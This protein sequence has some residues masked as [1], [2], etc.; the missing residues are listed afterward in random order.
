M[1]LSTLSNANVCKALYGGIVLRELAQGIQRSKSAP[2]NAGQRLLGGGNTW[3]LQLSENTVDLACWDYTP[4]RR[5]I[6]GECTLLTSRNP[7]EWRSASSAEMAVHGTAVPPAWICTIC[8]QLS[9][10]SDTVSARLAL[11]VQAYTH[12]RYH[13][14]TPAWYRCV[15]RT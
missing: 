10:L 8:V 5:C 9:K 2:P 6:D 7:G 14:A 4:F 11:P 15:Q 1:A 12:A 3:L 13:R